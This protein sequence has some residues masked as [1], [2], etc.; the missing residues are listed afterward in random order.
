LTMSLIRKL[1]AAIPHDKAAEALK[2]PWARPSVLG[3]FRT[4]HTGLTY[5]NASLKHCQPGKTPTFVNF[6]FLLA[7]TLT[8]PV[9]AARFLPPKWLSTTGWELHVGKSC[10]GWQLNLKPYCIRP[11]DSLVFQYAMKRNIDGLIR[12]CNEGLASPR[13]CDLNG[14]TALTVSFLN[15]N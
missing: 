8:A 11:N 12:L 13:D 2:V 4:V 6:S 10:L 15:I 3:S 9:F 1:I 14:W 7:E 5:V